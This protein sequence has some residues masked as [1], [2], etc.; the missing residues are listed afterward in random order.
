MVGAKS[1]LVTYKC[2]DIGGISMK[3]RVLAMSSADG[4][5]LNHGS[6]LDFSGKIA[7]LYAKKKSFREILS[8]PFKETL[9]RAEDSNI[10]SK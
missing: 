7:G 5:V 9:K 2:T 8:E 1:G 4:R 3:I 10:G 6:I